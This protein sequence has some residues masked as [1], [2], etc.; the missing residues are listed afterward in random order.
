MVGEYVFH[1]GQQQVLKQKLLKKEI[2]MSESNKLVVKVKMPS[3]K[4][5]IAVNRH[6]AEQTLK[7]LNPKS[8]PNRLGL[9][10]DDSGSM[11]GEAIVHAHSAVKNFTQSCN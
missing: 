4:K 7:E 2:I 9:V 3:F 5:G 8:V 6:N 11:S 10:F 1:V